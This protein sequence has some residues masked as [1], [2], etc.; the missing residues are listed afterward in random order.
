MC[1]FGKDMPNYYLLVILC[2]FGY[3]KFGYGLAIKKVNSFLLCLYFLL[4]N[5]FLYLLI[6]LILEPVNNLG[7]QECEKKTVQKIQEIKGK[8]SK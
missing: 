4:V 6:M 7:R 5:I 3:N 2:M 8:K 1:Q